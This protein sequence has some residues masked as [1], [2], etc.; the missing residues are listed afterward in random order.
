MGLRFTAVFLAGLFFAPSVSAEVRCW[1]RAFAVGVLE[2]I[3]KERVVSHGF[4]LSGELVELFVSSQNVV[5]GN[6]WT[7]TA[8]DPRT[9]VLC[10]ISNG[11]MWLDVVSVDAAQ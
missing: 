6:T 7:I 11:S 8:T 4:S 10:L 1:D 9:Q 3:Y 5:V 2:K